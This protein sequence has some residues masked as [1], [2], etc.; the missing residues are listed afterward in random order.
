MYQVGPMIHGNVGTTYQHDSSNQ[1]RCEESVRKYLED[2]AIS[3][4]ELYATR[5]VREKTSVGLRNDEVGKIE[6]PSNMTYRSIYCGWCYSMGYKPTTDAKGNFG[7]VSEFP[8]RPYDEVLCQLV[9]RKQFAHGP[10]FK[11][12]GKHFSL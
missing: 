5:F 1:R 3:C 10:H 2:L 7:P 6:L 12:F 9:Q 11:R 8:E 4:A